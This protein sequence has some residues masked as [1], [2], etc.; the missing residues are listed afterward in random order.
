MRGGG[1]FMRNLRN[2]FFILLGVLSATLILTLFV[3]DAVQQP[4]LASTSSEGSL[5]MIK[6]GKAAGFCPLKHTDVKGGISGF[7]ARVTVTQEFENPSTEK[8]EAVYTFPLPQDS[9]VDDMTITIGSRTIIG[10][11]KRR[12]EAAAIYKQAIQQ[13]KTAALLDQERPNI[14]TQTVGNI[15]PGEKIDV[16]ISYTMRL[17]YENGAYEFSFPMVVGPRYIPGSMEIGKQGGGVAPDTNQVPDASKITP[18]IARPGTR[19]GHDIS[20]AL[21]LDA[22]VPIQDLRSTT[23][24][25]DVDRTG[26]SSAI[27]RLRNES[28]IP[29][30]D[31]I[32]RYNVAGG[33]IAEGLITHTNPMPVVPA[34]LN[35]SAVTANGYF[36]LILQ[37]PDR[38]R[39]SDVTPKELVFVID[40]SGSMGGF[41]IEKSK[42]LIDHA[43]DGLYPGDTFN[44]IKFSGDTA[45]LF[46]EPVYPTAANV[47]KAKDFV[48]ANWGGQ[49]TEM[50]KAIRAA[51][52]P[53]DSQDHLRIVVFLTDGYV[54]NDM[55]IISE[56]QKHPNAR[57]F[58]Y[59]IG[60]SVNRFL[61][62]KMAEAGRGEVEYVSAKEDEKEAEAAA[63][64]LYER[65]RAPLLTD[66]SIDFGSLPVAEVYPQKIRDLFS[67]R[68]VIITG[69]YTAGAEGTIRLKGKRAGE[70][71]VRE[72]PVSFPALQSNNPAVASLWAREKIDD[73]MSQD[74]NGA[75]QGEMKKDLREQI[76]NIGLEYRLMTQFTSFVAVEERVVTEGG[77]PKRIQVPVEL[78]EDV[79]YEEGW[80]DKRA[81]AGFNAPAKSKM[82][83]YLAAPSPASGGGVGAGYG[84]GVG[85]GV[86]GGV[87]GGIVSNASPKLA[88]P[89]RV[90]ISQEVSGGQLEKQVNPT[91][92]PLAK[93]ARIQ[94]EVVLRAVVDKTGTISS[95]RVV[96]GH[97]MLAPAA[98]E[99]VKQW[100]Y[101]PYLLNGT[102]VEVETTISVKFSES[103]GVTSGTGPAQA[104]LN[105]HTTKPPRAIDSKLSPKLVAAYDCWQSQADK[106]NAATACK[107][108][109]N[110]VLVRVIA[111]GDPAAVL[112]QLQA[113]GFEPQ[114][115]AARSKQLVGRIAVAKL[116][117]LAEIA[118]VKFV[119]PE[120]SDD[121]LAARKR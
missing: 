28:E 104:I 77:K 16:S 25:I 40:S 113:A 57:V 18:P 44:V 50:M 58:A 49:G 41:P 120:S 1:G 111:T 35:G 26:A 14:F 45:I 4:V 43:I 73:L 2:Q 36:T 42:R 119:S 97:P 68:P 20:I 95:L 88:T 70:P 93:R 5:Q 62:D 86:S 78:P 76:T 102:P 71:Y 69:R 22:G 84:G 31:F 118:A 15:P 21:N 27:V 55:E 61:L 105:A 90:R 114:A 24:Q 92:P 79:Q 63:N 89:Q 52:A 72:I 87:L 91:Y 19:A 106:S 32:F 67:A 98:I 74:W 7:I 81:D 108:T 11:I 64:R 112:Q 48:N 60:S 46:D 117:A 53:S 109:D 85:S 17:K 39:E 65:L 8:I 33:S 29:N 23:H 38:F 75:Q 34:S 47:R 103:A 10:Q 51:L 83:T 3:P 116:A 66:I 100:K 82:M 121:K 54:G 12:E 96:S 30:K 9:A 99:A 6:G 37:P 94:G 115:E 59:G 107:L 101:K 110:K 13:G 56:V 80:S